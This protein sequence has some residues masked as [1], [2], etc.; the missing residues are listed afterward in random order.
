MQGLFGLEFPPGDLDVEV[1]LE[2]KFIPIKQGYSGVSI[3]VEDVDVVLEVSVDDSDMVVS[4]ASECA[5]HFGSR[6]IRLEK[7]N[8]S[9]VAHPQELLFLD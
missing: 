7:Q 6:M 5:Y 8:V 1:I 4:T 9:S 3:G 2:N